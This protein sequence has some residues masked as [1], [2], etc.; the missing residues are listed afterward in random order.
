MVDKETAMLCV[1]FVIV[2]GIG[3]FFLAP[4]FHYRT[5]AFEGKEYECKISFLEVPEGE[6]VR[7]TCYS[8]DSWIEVYKNDVL[9]RSDKYG[10]VYEKVKK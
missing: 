3:Y 10:R 6:S 1:L 8:N 4:I 5:I 7:H 2:L 9:D